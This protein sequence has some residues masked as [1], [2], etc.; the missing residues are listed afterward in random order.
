MNCSSCR[1]ELSVCLDGRL[2]AGRRTLV[3]QH[4][5]QCAEC[6]TFWKE[7]QAAQQL[8][9]RLQRPRVSD[10]FRD[11]LWQRIQAGEGTPDAVFREPV[12]L[13][14]K[15]RY[16]LAGA[17]AAAAALLCA[18]WLAPKDERIAE[19]IARAENAGGIADDTTAPR[20]RFVFHQDAPPL[21]ESPM[22]S[23][24]Q[25]LR[26]QLVATETA[27][28]LDQRLAATKAGLQRLASPDAGENDAH[29]VFANAEEFH[30][31][32][33]LLLDMRDGDRLLFADDRVEPDLRYAVS[34][35]ERLPLAVRNL[36]TARSLVAPAFEHYRPSAVARSIAPVQLDPRE[37]QELLL[38][39]TTQRPDIFPKLFFVLG[40]D[41]ELA[42]QFGRMQPGSAFWLADDCG[43]SWVAPRS[44]V[45]S[46]EGLVRVMRGRRAGTGAVQ[47]EI[48]VESRR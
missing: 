22:L 26:F 42:Y 19:P 23:A 48:H 8:T 33:E 20:Q 32:G 21:D 1:Y 46:R 47:V 30:T 2:P 29:E 10:G 40:S 11:S 12:P 37:E 24:T 14:A 25:R 3:L 28:Q 35:L 7:L 44:E 38:R 5:A 16:A 4:A 6:G 27:R 17:A 41:T 34:M 13:L 15:V 18:T 31:F 9:L 36:H 39:L 45:E 43:P